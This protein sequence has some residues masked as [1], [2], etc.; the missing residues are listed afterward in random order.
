M[1]NQDIKRRTFQEVCEDARRVEQFCI[2]YIN[3][4][5]YWKWHEFVFATL[6][7][8]LDKEITCETLQ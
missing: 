8:H 7:V 2:D 4:T 1:V 3:Q 6:W 5:K